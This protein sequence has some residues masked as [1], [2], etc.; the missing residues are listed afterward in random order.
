MVLQVKNISAKDVNGLIAEGWTVLDV[1]PPNE[2]SKAPL[3]D[4]V[5][6]RCMLY[7][8]LC[9]TMLAQGYG[10]GA[11]VWPM[12]EGLGRIMWWSEFV[13]LCTC[14]MCWCFVLRDC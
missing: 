5:H 1:R 3:A 13:A 8:M 4:A 11:D 14:T 2:Q 7:G 6:V 10:C 9:V 12:V